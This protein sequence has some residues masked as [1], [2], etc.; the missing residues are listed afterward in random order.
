VTDRFNE[1]VRV[2]AKLAVHLD[3]GDV[4]GPLEPNSRSGLGLRHDHVGP[5]AFQNPKCLFDCPGRGHGKLQ[6]GKH[7]L[8]L[9]GD[10]FPT[11][12]H[13]HEGRKACNISGSTAATRLPSSLW[14]TRKK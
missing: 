10:G 9:L 13:Q 11:T 2:A 1:R 3:D 5:N 4:L 6:P 12:E 8:R 14:T 7:G